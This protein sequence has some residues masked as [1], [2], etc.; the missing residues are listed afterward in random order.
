MTKLTCS[1][2]LLSV[3]AFLALPAFAQQPLDPPLKDWP[4]ASFWAPS[5]ANAERIA[6]LQGFGSGQ[7]L[8][9][10]MKSDSARKAGVLAAVSAPGRAL[11]FV[12][13]TP[14]RLVDTRTSQPQT[15]AFGP[16]ALSAY[17]TRSFPLL[18]H[19]NCS[20]PP[21]A[22]A[23]SLNFT[24]IPATTLDFL[25]AW[26]TGQPY[27]TVST[28]NAPLGGV[29]ANAAIVPA[30]TNGS[31]DVVVGKPTELIIDINGYFAPGGRS[32]SGIITPDGTGQVLPF[33]AQRS[34]TLGTTQYTISFPAGT[35]SLGSTESFPVPMITPIGNSYINQVIFT[36]PNSNGS[37]SLLVNFSVADTTFYFATIQN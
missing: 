25:T 4:V 24:V 15:G 33:G 12:A 5:A 13:V 27:P 34:H 3:L 20:V 29:V 28:L 35:F 37:G 16:P 30:G 1:S 23:Y 7:E 8:R 9:R 17:S 31:I 21:T 36:G 18:T 32:I 2:S 10:E 11:S 19:P 26:P 22:L 14:C 6:E